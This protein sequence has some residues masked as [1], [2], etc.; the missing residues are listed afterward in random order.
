MTFAG[1]SMANAFSRSW[2]IT[3]LTLHVMKQDKELLLFPVFAGIFSILFLV[4]LLFPTIILA[5]VQE[6]EPVWGITAYALLFI[7]YLGL[8][9]IA[10]FFNV[11]VVYTAKRRFEGGNA[12][13]GESITFALS[14]IHLIFYWSLLSATVGLLLR[15]LERAAERGRGNIL[16]RFV[17]AGL[18]M[19][20]AI[21]TIFVVPSMVYYGLGPID[22]IKR[23]TQVLRK[24]WGESLIRHFGLGLVQFAFIIA[25][26]LASV[27]LVFLSVAL[28]PVALVM[29]IALI[30]LYFL[31]VI[32]VFAV[33]NTVFNTALF[34]YADKG[35]IPHGFSREVVQGAFRAKKAAGTI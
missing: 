3:K 5:F 30:V 8:A 14:K 2:E 13:F 15:M 35:K 16:L 19:A 7:A 24:T 10:T 6:G 21:L 32:L 9:F 23:S 22:A 11:C 27:A 12:T 4:A 29:A 25:G 17:A 31:A 34:V 1:G 18:G 20:W 26:I 28:C 33:A